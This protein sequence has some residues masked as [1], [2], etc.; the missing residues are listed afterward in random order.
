M[1]AT[2]EVLREIETMRYEMYALID[3]DDQMKNP[4]IL[5]ASQKVDALL[6]RYHELIHKRE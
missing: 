6:L 3:A 5:W 2:K 1:E 4:Q